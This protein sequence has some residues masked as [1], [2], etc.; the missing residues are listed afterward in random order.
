M[1]TITDKMCRLQL[2]LTS[3]NSQLQLFMAKIPITTHY[4]YTDS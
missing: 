4:N 3:D 2:L 1:I